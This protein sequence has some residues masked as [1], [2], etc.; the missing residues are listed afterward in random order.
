MASDMAVALARATLDRHT[1]FAHNSNRPRGEE[2]ALVRTVGRDHAPGEKVRA[3]HLLLPQV[4]HTYGVLAGRAGNVPGYQHGVNEKSVAA[5]CTPIRTR[6]LNDGPCLTGPDLVQ[7]ALERAATA[8]QAVEVVTDL[9]GRYGQGPFVG[10]GEENPD[11]AILI[12]DCREAHVLE[13]TGRHWALA[14][15]GSV[16]AVSNACFLHQDWD[17]IS[18]GLSD[19]AIHRGW[20][21]ED[22]CKLDFARAMGAPAANLAPAMRRWGQATMQL[23]QHSGTIDAAFLRRLLRIQTEAVCPLEGPPGEIETASSLI[24]RLGPE[25]ASMPVA[26]YSFGPPSASVY[27]PLLPVADPP[28][29]VGGSSDADSALRRLLGIWYDESRRN[30]RSRA[31][32]LSCLAELQQQLDE[33]AHEFLTEAE[34]LYRRGQTDELRRLAETFMQHTC[35]RVEDLAGSHGSRRKQI[36]QDSEA[37]AVLPGAEF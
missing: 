6:L 36:E 15:I 10:E 2:P 19:L 7:L 35:E 24:V 3:T 28:A 26:W 31:S 11:S 34:G 4:R 1:Y 5:G 20:W 23:E 27:L 13:A 21:P 18:R 17:R 9:I 22:G 30:P 8:L 12:A 25:P 33:L 29:A 14:T 32:L 37:E 16:R